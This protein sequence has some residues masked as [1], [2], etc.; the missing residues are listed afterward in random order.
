MKSKRI[1]KEIFDWGRTLIFAVLLSILISGFIVQPSIISE[2]SMEPTLVGQDSF[3]DDKVG[4]RVMIFKSVYILGNAP[5]YGDIVI[6]DSRVD[7]ERTFMD[8]I[9]D[10]PLIKRI[11]RENN[12]RHFWIKRVIGEAGDF[13]E[14]KEGTVY[15]NDAALVEDYIKEA[16]IGDF[17]SVLVP[18]NHVFVMGDNRNM[19]RDSREIGPVP[20]EN[21]VGKV[22]F[23]FYPFDKISKY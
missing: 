7:R 8:E 18:E 4:D 6:I 14:F 2:A 16:M 20:T 1:M 9:I 3:H 5:K 21:V 22:L 15:R 13:L 19:S 10:N 23:R 17:E 12:D 11:M